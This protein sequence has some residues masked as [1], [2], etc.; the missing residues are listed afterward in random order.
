MID[1][2]SHILPGIDD[3]ARTIEDSREIALRSVADGIT[4]IAA[5]PH[6]KD[7]YPTTAQAMEEGVVQL[8]RDFD[9]EGIPLDVL[10]G[11]ELDLDHV[12]ALDDG[13]LR[14]FTLAGTG[15]YLLI[16]CPYF[17]WPLGLEHA[18]A[19]LRYDGVTPILAHP[20][21][22]PEVADNPE[23]VARA[24]RAGALVQLTAASIEGR[25]GRRSKASAGDLLKRGLA[26]L[27]ASDAH[28]ADVREAGLATAAATIGD[29]GLARY[30]TVET[31]AAIVAGEDVPDVPPSGRRRRLRYF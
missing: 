4:A 20:E 16:E 7:R 14:K 22:N 5:T 6:V 1:L 8:Q 15:R 3:G 25:V 12:L 9:A 28:T 11:G 23:L 30:L 29:S 21:R 24:V 17:G 26:H 2:H 27:V 10:T 19:N 13:E 31:P 18:L